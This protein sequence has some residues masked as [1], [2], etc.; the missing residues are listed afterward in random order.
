MPDET[1]SPREAP[2]RERRHNLPLTQ[3]AF[4]GREHVMAE[5]KQA[6]SSTQLLTLTGA[7]GCGKT[8]LAVEM[9]RHLVDE[10]P[11]GVWMV[12][13]ASLAEGALVPSAVASVLGVREQPGLSFTETIVESLRSRRVLLVLDNCEH[14][15][16]DCAR[17]VDTILRSCERVRVLATSREALGV[18]GEV[19]RV[20]PSLTVPDAYQRSDPESLARY[21]SVRLF[22]GLARS[23]VSSFGLTEENAPAVAEVCRKLDGIPLAIELATA[24]LGALSVGQISERL[25]DSLGFLTTGDRTRSP[26]QR[27]LR[28]TLQWSYDLLSEPE[29]ELFGRLSVFA[30]GWTL[31]AAETMCDEGPVK[32]GEVVDLLS[33]LVEKSLVVVEDSP[34]DAGGLRYRMLEP[35]RQYALERL[36][37]GGGAEETRRQHAAYYL[38]LAEEARPKLRAAAQVEWLQRLDRENGNLRAA[39]SWAIS[40]GEMTIAAWLGWALWAFWW[41]RNHQME[42]RRWM[43]MILP[44]RD[45]L[46]PWLRTRA[47]I[48]TEAMAYGQGDGEAVVRYAGE[49]AEFSREAGGD[50]LADA[51]VHGGL[52]LVATVRGDL[53]AATEHLQKALPLFREADEEGLAAQSHTWLGTILLLQGDHA[54]ARQRF[55]EGLALGRSMGDRM[56]VHNALFNLAQLS[57][58]GGDYEAAARWFAEGIAPS[59]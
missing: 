3:S 4:V 16:E 53:E 8:R 7:G 46:S 6:L 11:D 45:E 2:I 42:G 20:V 51:F 24:R 56:C 57:L 52:G 54:G 44:R 1:S 31:A 58:A 18:T 59:E 36:T 21:E 39:L 35:I 49:L 14:L 47:L 9:A 13:L 5:V 19:N 30:G 12:Q 41:I 38:G 37:E 26:R 43:E 17:L 28:A 40:T 15:I 23:R 10:Y 55:E 25:E 27:T 33:A 48:A 29:R 34:S 50:A 22:V 32:A